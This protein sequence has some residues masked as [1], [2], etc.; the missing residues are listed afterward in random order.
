MRLLTLPRFSASYYQPMIPKE[1]LLAE[2]LERSEEDST[3]G[4]KDEYR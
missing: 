3:N 1:D 4:Y 2:S